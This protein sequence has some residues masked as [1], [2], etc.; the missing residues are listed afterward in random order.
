MHGFA[1]RG[2]KA[3]HVEPFWT[4]ID[5][6]VGPVTEQ[7]LVH[8][9]DGVIRF[10]PC[11]G[12]Q[13]NHLSSDSTRMAPNADR[14]PIHVLVL[15]EATAAAPSHKSVNSPVHLGETTGRAEGYTRPFFSVG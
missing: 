12:R 14:R 15:T 10:I 1:R 5:R 7:V 11:G 13:R 9:L 4:C 2:L 3:E 8:R 6:N